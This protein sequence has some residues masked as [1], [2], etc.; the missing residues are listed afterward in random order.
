MNN[1]YLNKTVLV[2]GAAGTVGRE[3]VRRLVGFGPKELRILDNN[4]SALFFQ[5]NEYRHAGRVIPYLG[6][7]R[8]EHKLINVTRGVDVLLHLAAFKHVALAEYNPFEAVQTNI[9]GVRNVAQAAQINHV[10]RAIFASSDKA[11]NPTNVMG[12]SKLMGERIFSAAN[13]FRNNGSQIFSS[14][15]FGNVLGSRGSVVPV[16]IKQILSGAAV[17]VTDVRMTRFVMTVQEAAKLLLEAPLIAC[18]GEVLVAKML[19][20]RIIDLAHALIELLSAR[21]GM[22]P[23]SVPVKFV[24]AMPGEK[25]YEE[26]MT[27]E[28]VG[29]T[30]E[31]PKMFAILPALRGFYQSIEYNYKN[32]LPEVDHRRPYISNLET[33]MTIEEIKAFLENCGILDEFLSPGQPY[34]LPCP[35]SDLTPEAATPKSSRQVKL[36]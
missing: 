26:L 13:I 14:V 6:D 33:P 35:A 24:G 25:L 20:V 23:K 11:V 34:D 17:T 36:Q 10:P 8:D 28:E 1:Y 4:E 2:T 19:A 27:E 16:F 9:V 29:R 21:T 5:G 7:V 31:L 12:T 15:R 32:I 22:N 3:V 30:K 18:G